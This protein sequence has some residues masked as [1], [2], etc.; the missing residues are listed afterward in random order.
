MQGPHAR[1]RQ[2]QRRCALLDVRPS[3]P[4]QRPAAELREDMEP[5]HPLDT[6]G[7]GRG[8]VPAA[9]PLLGV[10]GD[11]DLAR[12]RRRLRP[13][14]Q[15]V[16]YVGEE[17]FGI[18]FAGERLRSLRTVRV[19]PPPGAVAPV[20]PLV[21]TRHSAC[22][23][24][25]ARHLPPNPHQMV[26][27]VMPPRH[28]AP[29]PEHGGAT[30]RGRPADTGHAGRSAVP[31]VRRPCTAI[32]TGSSQARPSSSQALQVQEADRATAG[33]GVPAQMKDEKGC[34]LA[35]VGP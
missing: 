12:F 14:E 18:A 9:E 1:R 25:R 21:D 17:E 19:L 2:W 33:R 4:S 31:V 34:G 8:P 7:G 30:P 13:C 26:R 32:G 27:R 16:L 15:A 11:R 23:P 3:Q 35:Q 28:G 24:S 5:K 20:R 10:D 29:D 6:F 22:P